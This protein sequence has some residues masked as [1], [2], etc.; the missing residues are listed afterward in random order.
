MDLDDPDTPVLRALR[1]ALALPDERDLALL[2]RHALAKPDEEPELAPEVSATTRVR[3]V[4]L[5]ECGEDEAERRRAALLEL[6]LVPWGDPRW[7]AA[8]A[9]LNA[10][11]PLLYLRGEGAWPPAQPVTIVGARASTARGR[12]FA[13]ELGAGVVE[14]GGSV[15]SGLAVGIDQSSHEGALDA[16]GAA[17]A[18]LACGVDQIYPPGARDLAARVEQ[19]GRIVSE[20]ALGTPP[21]KVHFPRRNRILAALSR[22]TLVVEADL[23]SGS[24][25]TAHRAL[26]LGRS[27]HA[28]PGAIDSP[29]SRGTNRLVRDGAHPLLGVEDLDLLLPGLASASPKSGGANG[30]HSV[31][32]ATDVLLEQLSSP[33][34]SDELAR[35]SGVALDRLLVRLVE[36]EADGRVAR[37]GGGMYVRV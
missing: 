28:V 7:P 36:L 34:S 26:E 24:L 20:M 1:I 29:T 25:V 18:V 30:S 22:A 16:K 10:P 21:Y 19:S 37:L 17:Y 27:V 23:K 13:R 35:R 32:G 11:P 6:E 3:L 5:R 8:L 2:R 12:A 31:N 33:L 14:R 9:D 4:A 15:V